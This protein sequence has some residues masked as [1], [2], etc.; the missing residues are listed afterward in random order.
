MAHSDLP[1]KFGFRPSNYENVQRRMTEIYECAAAKGIR[2][3]LNTAGL[4]VAADEIYPSTELLRAAFRAGMKI[5]LGSDAHKPEHVAYGFDRA[6]E[7][8]RSIGWT[9]H[10]AFVRGKA[11]ELPL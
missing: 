10:T 8:A 11:I 6:A 9:S 7:L 2:L 1:K 3:E 5:T 4:R